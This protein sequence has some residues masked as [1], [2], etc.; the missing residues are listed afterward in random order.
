MHNV[1]CEVILDLRIL[2]IDGMLVVAVLGEGGVEWLEVGEGGRAGSRLEGG[3]K[4]EVVEE[5]RLFT[6]ETIN[7]IDCDSSL[8]RE[9][10]GQEGR[11]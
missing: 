5:V 11:S 2:E 4:F 7:L 6:Y 10:A 9:F 1:K 3:E 8:T